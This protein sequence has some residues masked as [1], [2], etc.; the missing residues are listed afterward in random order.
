MTL[1]K[2]GL[3]C[4]ICGKPLMGNEEYW[5]C[6]INGKDNCH[7]CKACKEKIEDQNAKD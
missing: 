6:S 3:W 1:R 4:D 2:S 7:A 5:N